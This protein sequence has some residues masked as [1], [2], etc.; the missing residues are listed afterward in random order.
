MLSL[1]SF[2][3]YDER[4]ARIVRENAVDGLL[5]ST[6]IEP[7]FSGGPTTNDAGEVVGINV[8]KDHAHVGQNGAVSVVALRAL[9]DKVK[10]ASDARR[11]EA[12]GHR[13][14]AREGAERVLAAADRGAQPR[15][16]DRVPRARATCRRCASFVGEVRREER[17]TDTVVHRE[18]NISPA[19]PRSAS[20]S[21]ASPASCSRP[22]A[23]RRRPSRS[24]ACDAVEPPPRRLPRR[25]RSTIS[26][27]TRA[28]ADST[29]DELA[30]RPLAWDL[31]A[32]TLQWDGKEKHY[33]VTKL[34]R[35]DDEGNTFRAVGADLR[36]DEPGR[37]VDRHGPRDAA[38]QAVRSDRQPLRDR[39][40]RATCRRA[41]S[42]ARG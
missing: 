38:P 15:P 40:R 14:A 18:V 19:R 21:R 27:T 17:N 24:R 13:R 7:G 41:R 36:R 4:Y 3:A 42:R 29:C 11:S 22:I 26:T 5:I 31:A 32:A 6:D 1:V 10:P 30:L 33:T 9:L 39:R 37:A 28:L 34:E 25:P 23:R 16:R 2:P 20:T 12:R 35:M 8:T